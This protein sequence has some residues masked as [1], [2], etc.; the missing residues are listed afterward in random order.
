MA[1]LPLETKTISDH[2]DALAPD[3]SEIR[4]L[5]KT[6]KASMVHCTLPEGRVSIPVRHQTVEEL[7]YFISGEGEVWRKN[8][9]EEL[10]TPVRAGV[11]I[12]VSRH[13][14][15]HFRNTGK[16]PLSFIIAT[17]PPWPGFDEDTIEKNG[18]WAVK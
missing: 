6:Q 5:L 15:F 12:S 14:S 2:Y 9:L 4:L 18:N 8:D 13:T 1:I 3:G 7:W 10:V 17:M 11:S 16:E